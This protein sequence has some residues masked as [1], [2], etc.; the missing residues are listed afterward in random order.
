MDN[1]EDMKMRLDPYLAQVRDNAQAKIV[2]LNDLLQSQMED[3]KDSL[4]ST[5]EDITK[6]AER[7]AE[8][9]Q[10]ALGDKMQEL[11]EWFQ[12][13]VSMFRA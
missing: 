7:T 2:T 3:L 6:R 8:N 12:P 11:N 9:L 1:V 5:A 13:F 10:S 4:Q